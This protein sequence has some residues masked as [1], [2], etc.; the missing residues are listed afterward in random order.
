MK[1]K[2]FITSLCFVVG[3]LGFG[4][5]KSKAQAINP[6]ETNPAVEITYPTGITYP[7]L[8]KETCS[9]EYIR[10]HPELY[11]AVTYGIF[12]L[13]K[14]NGITPQKLEKAIRETKT[15]HFEDFDAIYTLVK[16]KALS[17]FMIACIRVLRLNP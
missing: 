9:G 16:P 6:Q 13:L 3:L 7:K 5:N 12:Q 4:Q 1:T 11:K 10:S 15:G 8:T 17:H 2:P 14:K